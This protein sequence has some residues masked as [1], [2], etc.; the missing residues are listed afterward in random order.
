MQIVGFRGFEILARA[1]AEVS[2]L[3][4]Q[5]VAVEANGAATPCFDEMGPEL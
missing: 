4:F 2:G 5:G 3:R 1:V